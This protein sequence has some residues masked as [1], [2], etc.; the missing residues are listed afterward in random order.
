MLS[1]LSLRTHWKL[2]SGRSLL[3]MGSFNV[4]LALAFVAYVTLAVPMTSPLWILAWDYHTLFSNPFNLFNANIFYPAQN[5]L[6][7]S[8]Q[9][10]ANLIIFAPV[11]FIT[12]NPV[13]A[14]CRGFDESTNFPRCIQFGGFWKS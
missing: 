9:M 6:A 12:Q 1:V 3:A 13:L 8:E 10:V 4:G 11:M 5:T 7:L 14:V 2:A